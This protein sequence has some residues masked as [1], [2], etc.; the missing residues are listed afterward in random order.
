[1]D[2]IRKSYV[3]SD[4]DEKNDGTSSSS[5][6]KSGVKSKP[7]Y[8]RRRNLIHAILYRDAD[9]EKFPTK[10]S[11]ADAVLDAFKPFDIVKHWVCCREEYSEGGE[12]KYS[13]RMLVRIFV[14][15]E[16]N[17]IPQY[18]ERE[19]NT[20]VEFISGYANYIVAYSSMCRGDI[21][22]L[23]SE[24]HPETN[25]T[26]THFRAR[27]QIKTADRGTWRGSIAATMNRQAFLRDPRSQTLPGACGRA[28][29]ETERRSIVATMDRQMFTGDPR[30]Q[31]LPDACKSGRCCFYYYRSFY[32]IFC[33]IC[34][35]EYFLKFS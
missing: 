28:D 13:Y 30:S 18:F 10:E 26:T 15:R 3:S 25:L 2:L 1:M 8:G 4:E 9:L 23:H 16:A 12:K 19:Y 31:T 27:S 21:S 34:H 5:G 29:R 7:H 17:R 20:K 22:P 14:K 11:F 24:G 33:A 35:R 32:R 6:D